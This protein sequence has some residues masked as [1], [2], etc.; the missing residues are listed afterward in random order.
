MKL[1]PHILQTNPGR[2]NLIMNIFQLIDLL[3]EE[4]EDGANVLLSPHKKKVDQDRIDEIISEM[5]RSLPEEIRQ[6]EMIRQEKQRIL[7]DARLQADAIIRDAERRARE[8]TGENEIV[9][10]ATEKANEILAA[11]NKNARDVRAGAKSYAE[12]ILDELSKYFEEYIEIVR[13]N[14]QSLSSKN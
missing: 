10:M 13:R 3:E 6:A 8:M 9:K 4:I 5:R 2:S 14:K 1:N 7:E 12:D 11:A